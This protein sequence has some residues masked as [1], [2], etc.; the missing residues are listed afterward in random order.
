MDKGYK[1]KQKQIILEY[2]KSSKDKHIT[3]AEIVAH[4]NSAGTSVGVTT[5][6]RY[7]DKLV[8]IGYVRK[9]NLDKKTGAC[10]QY[11]KDNEECVEH[12][13]LKC[14]KCGELYHISCDFMQGIDEHV[15]EHHGFRIDNTKTVLYGKC[16]H[17]HS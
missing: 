3:A 9:Y 5:V 14:V 10:Y 16:K 2:I 12:F 11:I 1:T 8:E 6:Y 13:H 17:C 15:L 7:L 4:L